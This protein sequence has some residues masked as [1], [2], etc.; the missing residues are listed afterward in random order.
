MIGQR[1]RDMNGI[2]SQYLRIALMEALGLACYYDHESRHM[3]LSRDGIVYASVGGISEME[4]R[5]A[6]EA[7]VEGRTPALAPGHRLPGSWQHHEQREAAEAQARRAAYTKNA[8]A[9]YD[10]GVIG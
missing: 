3:L 6:F 4:A 1:I 7:H 5:A 9:L 2:G 8:S 10:A